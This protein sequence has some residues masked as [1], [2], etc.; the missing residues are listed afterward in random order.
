MQMD[1]HPFIMQSNLDNAKIVR[2]F[3]R[4]GADFKGKSKNGDSLLE[5]AL[6][7]KKQHVR[8]ILIYN[9]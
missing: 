3:V 9:Q 5:V 4:N 1:I 8:N 2:Y 7:D 6:N